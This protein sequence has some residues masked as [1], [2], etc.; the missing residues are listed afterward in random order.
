MHTLTTF[1]DAAG[2]LRACGAE[3]EGDECLNSLILGSALTGYGGEPPTALFTVRDPEN[4]LQLAGLVI[5]HGR[6]LL[7]GPADDA[8]FELA[9]AHLTSSGADLATVTGSEPLAEGFGRAWQSLTGRTPTLAMRQRLHALE[10][11]AELPEPPGRMR[12]AELPDLDRVASWM[13]EFE[14]DLFGDADPARAR[15]DAE[16]R[17]R[18]REV[19][20]WDDGEARAM[21]ARAR[22]T[23][24]TETV[25]HVF[26]PES[27]RGRGY[28]TGLVA[29]LSRML[30]T[31]GCE[32][33]VL[34]TDL[35]NPVSN[36]IYARIGYEPVADFTMLRL[37]RST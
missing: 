3:M 26:T 9:A 16:R 13:A 29:A 27:Q 17:V 11:V 25:N 23:R 1:A 18:A 7:A 2:W 33:C 21:A 6:L 19:V 28:A 34:F 14:R 20:L 8:A 12:L 24:T 10:K 22:R 32:R 30:L 15:A 4:G 36:A 5:P 37:P 31:E 35:A